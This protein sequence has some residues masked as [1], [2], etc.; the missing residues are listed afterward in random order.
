MAWFKQ[1]DFTKSMLIVAP[2]YL[3]VVSLE[4]TPQTMLGNRR[5]DLQKDTMQSI[6]IYIYFYGYSLSNATNLSS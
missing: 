2:N 4:I 3:Y 6:A 5:N 1:N